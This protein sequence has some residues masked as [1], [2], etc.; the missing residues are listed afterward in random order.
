[1]KKRTAKIAASWMLLLTFLV[2]QAIVFGHTHVLKKADYTTSTKKNRA[3]ATTD[4]QCQIC[5]Q[6]SHA[7]LF[8]Q[9]FHFHFWTISSSYAYLTYTPVYEGV[10]LLLSGN[11]GPPQC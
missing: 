7:P 9:T 2:G 4:D 8:L 1:M 11:R 5:H 6:S 3:G 10:K